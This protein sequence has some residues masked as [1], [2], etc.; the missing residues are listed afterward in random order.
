[1]HELL[2]KRGIS[3]SFELVDGGGHAW[4]SGFVQKQLE[5]SLPFVAASFTK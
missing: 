4:G 5:K 1:M 3:H 2:K